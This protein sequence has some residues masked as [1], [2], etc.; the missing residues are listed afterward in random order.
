V[1]MRKFGRRYGHAMRQAMEVER[2]AVAAVGERLR[3][4]LGAPLPPP[5]RVKRGT[6]WGC[7][8]HHTE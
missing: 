7:A 8:M 6:C 3:S 4:T 5:L 1:R 2:P